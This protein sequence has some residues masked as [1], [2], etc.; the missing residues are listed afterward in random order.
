M[1][2]YDLMYVSQ[3][4]LWQLHREQIVGETVHLS[5][6]PDSQVW[7]V[8]PGPLETTAIT[9]FQG[10][11]IICDLYLNTFI[12]EFGAMTLGKSL[13]KKILT[14]CPVLLKDIMR[15]YPWE[16]QSLTTRWL[17]FFFAC[18]YLIVIW[19]SALT[20]LQFHSP[21]S[22]RKGCLRFKALFWQ[23]DFITFLELYSRPQTLQI[24]FPYDS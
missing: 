19:Q 11:V 23:D 8:L 14:L 16:V 24:C 17:L 6:L 13:G 22:L 20:H 3:R 15:S 10:K 9:L 2:C 18:K 4:S 12:T 1:E 21:P 7:Y 5:L